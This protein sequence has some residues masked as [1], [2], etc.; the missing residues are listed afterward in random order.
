[1]T[2][3]E[4]NHPV[5]RMAA[6][7]SRSQVRAS[8]AAAIAHFW[9]TVSLTAM[10]LLVLVSLGVL[11][12]GCFRSTPASPEDACINNMRQIDGAKR[13]WMEVHHKT[14]NDTPTWDDIRPYL[15]GAG[16]F[17]PA[18]PAGGTY[19]LGRVGEPPACS[20]PGHKLP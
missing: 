17:T 9:R 6:G 16:D 4:A 3:N 10:K 1:M 18:C 15:S 2:H 12:T 19:T 20:Y 11:L 13:Q 5:E 8:W 14:T 7:G